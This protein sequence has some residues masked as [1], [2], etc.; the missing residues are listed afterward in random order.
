M[1]AEMLEATTKQLTHLASRADIVLQGGK[2]FLEEDLEA[3]PAV[4]CD[5]DR[6]NYLTEKSTLLVSCGL[7]QAGIGD[8]G[9]PISWRTLALMYG[10]QGRRE[11]YLSKACLDMTFC[12][13][14]G[15]QLRSKRPELEMYLRYP[16]NS[17]NENG[18]A[19]PIICSDLAEDVNVPDY[20]P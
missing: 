9:I 5:L 18:P 7:A 10:G 6:N 15:M 12:G 8:G 16:V 1:V 3:L 14:D 19:F 2:D 20:A 11:T 17:P 4:F 13:Y